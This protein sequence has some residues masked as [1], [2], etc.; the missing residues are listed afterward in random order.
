[1]IAD[2]LERGAVGPLG[3]SIEV[4]RQVVGDFVL[5]GRDQ[6]VLLEV[7]RSDTHQSLDR[8]RGPGHEF[9]RGG[10]PCRLSRVDLVDELLGEERFVFDDT[11][12][13]SGHSQADDEAETKQHDNVVAVQSVVLNKQQARLARADIYG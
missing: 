9:R 4:V 5:N 13:G 11:G 7:F 1:M 8:F 3:T 6:L 12:V 10:L 2:F